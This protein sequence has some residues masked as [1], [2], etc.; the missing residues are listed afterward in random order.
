MDII[1]IFFF[2]FKIGVLG[3]ITLLVSYLDFP[4][5][6]FTICFMKYLTTV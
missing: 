1:I 5:N 6:F 2:F 4:N 3:Q